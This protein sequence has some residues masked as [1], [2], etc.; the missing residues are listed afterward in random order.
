MT[1]LAATIADF[2]RSIGMEVRESSLTKPTFLP[3]LTI[4][5][6][7]LVYDPALLKYPGDLLHEAGHI[8]LTPTSDRAAISGTA[9]PDG[10]LKMGA[11]AWSWAALLRLGLDPSIVF[12]KRDIAALRAVTS[13]IF[14]S[15]TTSASRC[16]STR[17]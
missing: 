15:G 12:M 9:D 8:A 10:G 3:G 2:L 13:R 6:G 14:A 5:H 11:I 17:D 16:C 7:A 1:D 4:D